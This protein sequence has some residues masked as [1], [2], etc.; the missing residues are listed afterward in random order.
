MGSILCVGVDSWALRNRMRSYDGLRSRV[1]LRRHR[2][3]LGS[4]TSGVEKTAGARTVKISGTSMI[5]WTETE[6]GRIGKGGL[7]GRAWFS[8]SALLPKLDT[9]PRR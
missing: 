7:W 8:G 1:E 4:A 6:A 3:C 5:P 9:R 2:R